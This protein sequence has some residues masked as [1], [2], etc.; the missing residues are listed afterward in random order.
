MLDIAKEL[1]RDPRID[2][3]V[4]INIVIPQDSQTGYINIHFKK[5]NFIDPIIWII[6]E[7]GRSSI[8][9]NVTLMSVMAFNRDKTLIPI[10]LQALAQIED[11]KPHFEKL[12]ELLNQHEDDY[13][14]DETN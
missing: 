9:E 14:A 13:P 3:Q 6:V 2:E 10:E 8:E 1:T 4:H 12:L 7:F 11:A 5:P